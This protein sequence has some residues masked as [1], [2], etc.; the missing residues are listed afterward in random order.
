MAV[1]RFTTSSRLGGKLDRQIAGRGT[2]EDFV[3]VYGGASIALR[4]ID[5]IA[6]KPA[7]ISTVVFGE[8]FNGKRKASDSSTIRFRP[9]VN[10]PLGGT[11]IAWNLP[12]A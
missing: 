5:P 4:A 9:A 10:N 7:S 8:A 11:M 1:L 12:S 6:R 2:F 3:D